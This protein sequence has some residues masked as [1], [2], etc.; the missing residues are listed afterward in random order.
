MK[1]IGA[2]VIAATCLTSTAYA[3]VVSFIATKIPQ[4]IMNH[5]D[6]WL[7]GFLQTSK[8]PERK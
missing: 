6:A 8:M 3:G 7:E 2:L 1:R 4:Q 5:G